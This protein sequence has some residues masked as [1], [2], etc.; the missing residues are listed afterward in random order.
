MPRLAIDVPSVR[1][2]EMRW[3]IILYAS[4]H[5]PFVSLRLGFCLRLRSAWPLNFL[6]RNRDMI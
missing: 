2:R 4:D 6:L 1:S 5:R 3:P